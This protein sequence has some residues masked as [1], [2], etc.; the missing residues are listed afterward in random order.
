M[1]SQMYATSKAGRTVAFSVRTGESKQ[2]LADPI[3]PSAKFCRP[4]RVLQQT[5]KHIGLIFVKHA[6]YMS[7]YFGVIRTILNDFLIMDA[8]RA[9]TSFFGGE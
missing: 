3:R 2:G 7:R 6:P 9:A 1:S 5:K 8:A 4:R